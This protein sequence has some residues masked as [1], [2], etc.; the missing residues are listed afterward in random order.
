[1]SGVSCLRAPSA[2][3][4]K[5]GGDWMRIDLDRLTLTRKNKV[6]RPDAQE[7]PENVVCR[8]SVPHATLT[9]DSV[10]PDSIESA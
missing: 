9:C 8:G 6:Q 4:R 3:L 1:M 10:H 7:A 2:P 5:A